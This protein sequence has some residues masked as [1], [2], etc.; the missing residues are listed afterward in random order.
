[1]IDHRDKLQHMVFLR[2]PVKQGEICG[3]EWRKVKANSLLYRLNERVIVP[4]LPR[5]EFSPSPTGSFT[6]SEEKPVFLKPVFSNLLSTFVRLDLRKKKLTMT[7][8]PLVVDSFAVCGELSMFAKI[9]E[10]QVKPPVIMRQFAG[11]RSPLFA[12]C[13]VDTETNSV[14]IMPDSGMR[15]FDPESWQLT[16]R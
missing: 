2:I 1:M 16:Y 14:T 6:L 3:F 13:A 10:N 8:D 5:T 15:I 12:V 9:F 11:I 4:R 7:E